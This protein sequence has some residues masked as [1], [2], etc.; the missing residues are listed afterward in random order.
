MMKN[1]FHIFAG[2][3]R[4]LSISKHKPEFLWD[5]HNIR[6][7]P[8]EGDTMMS[9][10][11]ERG[12]MKAKDNT[13]QDINLVGHYLGH[14]VVGST[15]IVFTKG[16][17]DYIYKIEYNGS[18]YTINYS[19]GNLSFG[20]YV[21]AVSYVE[22]E[23]IKKVYWVDGVN[24][25]R[26]INLNSIVTRQTPII[27]KDVDT[28]P[29]V[30]LQIASMSVEVQYGGGEFP[31]GVI[32]YAVTYFNKYGTET[33]IIDVSPLQY[34]KH[35][36]RGGSPEEKINVGFKITLTGIDTAFGY[37][38]IY[39]ILR[40][41][42]N[43]TPITKRVA[44]IPITGSTMTFTDTGIIG[45]SIN[46]TEL[47]YVGGTQL[48]P[49]T[50]AQKD[51]TLFLGN[52]KLTE[53]TNLTIP[54][55]LNIM[56]SASQDKTYPKFVSGEKYKLG[57]QFQ[58]RT[59]K[60]SKPYPI[61][62]YMT[63]NYSLASL[64]NTFYI[65]VFPNDDTRDTLRKILTSGDSTGYTR[66]RG[67]VCFPNDSERNIIMGGLTSYAT[68]FLYQNR[69]CT[70]PSWY[71]KNNNSTS[72]GDSVQGTGGDNFTLD[73]SRID[74]FSPDINDIVGLPEATNLQIGI[75][76]NYAATERHIK[77][78][79]QTSSPALR[80]AGEGN[81]SIVRTYS[82]GDDELEEVFDS[83]Y[84]YDDYLV[85]KSFDAPVDQ[86][87][88]VTF[89]VYAWQR[90]GS[91]NNDIV[92]PTDKGT[93]TA[94]LKEKSI[95]ESLYLGVQNLIQSPG[96]TTLSNAI[97]WNS[98]QLTLDKIDT[99]DY[100]GNV[101][102]S[103][104][105]EVNLEWR[106]PIPVFYY[107]TRKFN[108]DGIVEGESY[109][110]GALYTTSDENRTIV[111][112]VGLNPAKT[113][114]TSGND[115]NQN[116]LFEGYTNLLHSTDTIR[117]KYKTTPHVV[118]ENPIDLRNTSY[119]YCL[120]KRKTDIRYYNE[121]SV[122]VPAGK[123]FLLDA[124]GITSATLWEY[125]DTWF[126]DYECLRVY[127][128]TFEDTNQLTNIV[129]FPSINRNNYAAA[130]YDRN[131]GSLSGANSP[132][133]FN[134]LN[135]VYAQ[136]DNFFSYTSLDEDYYSNDIFSN[137]I[138]W[139]KEKHSQSIVDE[140]TN[141]T[142]AS[143]Y[144]AN[145]D[146]GSIT[147]LKSTLNNIY[148]FQERGVSEVLFNSRVQIPVSDGVPIEISNSR[149]VDGIRVLS[150]SIGVKNR[151]S[152]AK[153]HDSLYFIDSISKN[154]YNISAQGLADISTNHGMSSWF[155]KLSSDP[156]TASGFTEKTLYDQK[157]K[158]VYIVTDTEA[159]V[160]SEL[161]GQ[162]TSFMDYKEIPA[163]INLEDEVLTF[164]NTEDGNSDDICEVWKMFKGNYCHFFNEYKPYDITF[165]S[166]LDSTLDKTFTNLEVRAD[167]YWSDPN[168]EAGNEGSLESI[169]EDKDSPIN[170]RRLHTVGF[171]DSIRVWNEYQD[172]GEVPLTF[173]NFKTYNKSSF[174]S[175]N[176]AKKFRIWR[177]T[178][179]RDNAHKLDRIR[180]TWVKVKLSK[181]TEQE[182]GSF[183]ELHDL[184]VQYYI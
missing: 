100:M 26:M 24:Q 33:N 16:D 181:E 79:I 103:I 37:V 122:W 48:V 18:T 136:Q 14:C 3:Q 152:I 72:V 183:M 140:W 58:D 25:L 50:I 28:V 182:E 178:L 102:T 75:L 159:L 11:S 54:S 145:G 121:N 39:S 8:R 78:N 57:L 92:R 32:Q 38:R 42:I 10:T 30:N 43:G 177:V 113:Y 22:N 135:P 74:L 176:A 88:P 69:F 62:G 66:V 36:D 45:D 35:Q 169:I 175:T 129:T 94:V 7:T 82:S 127:P 132:A 86:V 139:T 142:L 141:I 91:L 63:A 20:D 115:Y 143:T 34:I 46:P 40:T 84:L 160:Y 87:A 73:Y 44:D 81:T 114:G 171:F 149:K 117:I 161:L 80:G 130:R 93:R 12:T 168:G 60:W 1:D 2:M 83:D 97:L 17:H 133:N 170:D 101:D 112:S 126:Q 27:P 131:R 124:T 128:F 23:N 180:N 5:A 13:N 106:S 116:T 119:S 51:N 179:P 21:E 109:W 98:D 184:S 125:G 157:N 59:G 76:A 95:I 146:Y 153:A 162:F 68:Q 67:L 150:D 96:F 64:V 172:S 19:W 110:K 15:L 65:R 148:C 29:T 151:W 144:A 41:S 173:K 107:R 158:D 156:W 123:P 85:T 70:I 147:A 174:T 120:L 118:M 90:T 31:A 71:I 134:L 53:N 111:E 99:K 6:F 163:I 165:I 55:R 154:L 108:P 166:N 4:D 155:S 89:K 56:S 52:I 9:I 104:L 77:V 138:T 167:F 49:S 137:E 61:D 47:F 105:T 164:K